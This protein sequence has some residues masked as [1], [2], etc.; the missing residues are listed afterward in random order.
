MY[1]SIVY[2]YV[3]MLYYITWEARALVRRQA[4]TE[5]ALADLFCWCWFFSERASEPAWWR[6]IRIPEEN[7]SGKR[8]TRR[9][10]PLSLILSL[11][12]S[13]SR[14]TKKTQLSVMLTAG[15]ARRHEDSRR[16]EGHLRRRRTRGRPDEQR[17]IAAPFIWGIYQDMYVYVCIYIYIYI[18]YIHY[19]TL[20]Y[21][22]LRYVTLHY[23][24]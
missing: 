13:L 17:R 18:T 11:S 14:R 24:T 7:H 3:Y 15:P 23:I 1:S 5:R 22:T 2:Y 16:R 8:S 10:R 21:V 12:L 20:R 4:S 19:I 9:Y 6:M